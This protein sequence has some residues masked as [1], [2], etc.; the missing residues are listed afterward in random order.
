MS[1]E[2]LGHAVTWAADG[3]IAIDTVHTGPFDLVFMDM[4]MPGPDGIETTHRI[5]ASDGINANVPI[6]ACTAL[7]SEETEAQ[8]RAAGMNGFLPKP[9]NRTK[10]EDVLSDYS[11]A[12]AHP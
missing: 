2:S 12:M 10:L 8:C 6:I 7:V 3:L 4:M 5:R 11:A 1:I 9:V